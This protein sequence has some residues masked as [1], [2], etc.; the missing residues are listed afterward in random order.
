MTDAIIPIGVPS[1]TMPQT[2]VEAVTLGLY[3]AI[4][5]PTEKKALECVEIAENIAKLASL[6]E[7]EV[8]TAKALAVAQANIM[9]VNFWQGDRGRS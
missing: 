9:T 5:A 4:T 8:D 2:P 7:H 6:T 3:L 1:N